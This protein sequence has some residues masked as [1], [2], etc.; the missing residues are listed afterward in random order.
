MVTDELGK[1][2]TLPLKNHMLYTDD[3]MEIEVAERMLEEGGWFSLNW[4]SPQMPQYTR[5]ETEELF[6]QLV[7]KQCMYRFILNNQRYYHIDS[8]VMRQ[9]DDIAMLAEKRHDIPDNSEEH[10]PP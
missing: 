5:E 6:E 1:E 9:L 3:P 7:E 8:E 10:L 4:I 2:Y